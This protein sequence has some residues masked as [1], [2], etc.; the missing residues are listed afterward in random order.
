MSARLTLLHE[1]KPFLQRWGWEC[2]WFGVFLHHIIAPDPGLDMH[3][4]PWPFISIVL[5]GG[6]SEWYA[7]IRSPN[8]VHHALRVAQRGYRVH[9]HPL[10]RIHRILTTSNRTW[11]IVVHG[12]TQTSNDNIHQKAWGFFDESIGHWIGHDDY[13]YSDRRPCSVEQSGRRVTS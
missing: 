1:G 11:T 10:R 3:D 7:D 6:Y 12:P 13:N 4:H 5:C 8:T 9:H 2:R